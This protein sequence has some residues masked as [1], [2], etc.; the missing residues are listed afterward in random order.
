MLPRQGVAGLGLECEGCSASSGACGAQR[1][2]LGLRGGK[3]WGRRESRTST[4]L[5]IL[6]LLHL[7]RFPFAS[8]F[9]PCGP[10][11][12]ASFPRARP[13]P[14][15]VPD[16]SAAASQE[17][18]PNHLVP[19][20]AGS[21]PGTACSD[22]RGTGGL[23]ALPLPVRGGAKKTCGQ[24][25][26]LLHHWS[27]GVSA[28][29]GMGWRPAPSLSSGENPDFWA[30]CSW[31]LFQER[32]STPCRSPHFVGQASPQ[33]AA[34]SPSRVS[35]R[36]RKKPRPGGPRRSLALPHLGAPSASTPG[37]RRGCQVT[38]FSRVQSPAWGSGFSTFPECCPHPAESATAPSV[39]SAAQGV[40]G[41]WR[42]RT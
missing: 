37:G 32:S 35:V 25:R 26:T 3:F 13:E 11:T 16:P 36:P 33:C 7:T 27:P 23:Q 38:G 18:R 6:A 9:N 10:T 42:L 17:T 28:C 21:A 20:G 1:D 15:L 29:G 19:R 30:L 2:R 8:L 5:G 41:R 39:C 34:A 12:K 14:R 31:V 40:A 22:L 24:T 4:F